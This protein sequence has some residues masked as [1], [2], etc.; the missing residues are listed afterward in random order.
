MLHAIDRFAR[1]HPAFLLRGARG[2]KIFAALMEPKKI[3]RR[4]WLR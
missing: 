4:I 3:M 2:T 1:Y